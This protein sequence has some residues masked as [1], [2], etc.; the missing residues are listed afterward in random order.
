MPNQKINLT[1]HD[2]EVLLHLARRISALQDYVDHIYDL[3]E[4]FYESEVDLI[5]FSNEL[6][7]LH[8]QIVELTEG[9]DHE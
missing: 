1:S 9:L 8:D 6:G 3:S 5:H 2:R 4:N 7:C